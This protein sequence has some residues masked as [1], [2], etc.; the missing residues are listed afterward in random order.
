M[1]IQ[2][3]MR[4]I[5][6]GPVLR[7]SLEICCKLGRGYASRGLSTG[8]GITCRPVRSPLMAADVYIWQQT[9]DI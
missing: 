5:I 9:G 7:I 3:Q 6:A 1:L 2:A 8:R 4:R